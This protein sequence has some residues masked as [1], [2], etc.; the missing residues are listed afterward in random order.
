MSP[1][2]K[3]ELVSRRMRH[4]LLAGLAALGFGLGM[5]QALAQDE[6]EAVAQGE[7][8]EETAAEEHA[9]VHYPLKKPEMM[10][11]SFAG[12]FGTYDRGQLQ[13]GFQVYREVCA[14]CHSLHYVAFRT[15][16]DHDGPG[17]TDAQVAALAAE[18]TIP[19]G[20]NADGEMFDR[21]GRPSDRFP[22]PFP[23]EQAA[24]V[25]NGGAAPPDLS[26]M[27][28]ARS[29]PRGPLNTVLDFFTQYQEAGPDY[30]HA[31][32]TGYDQEPPHGIVVPDGVYYNPYFLGGPALAMP[33]PLSDGVVTYADGS[34]ETIE[35]YSRD[36]SAFL[37]WA[38]EPHLV[39]RKRLG[40]EVMIFVL[41]FASLMYLTKRRV[42]AAVAH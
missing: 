19:D 31:L 20:P 24:A 7:A 3:D 41:V 27:A 36:V 29:A 23:N 4:T 28:K 2:R 39:A 38:A 40:F 8:V 34:P 10:D 37:M 14:S 32:L 26:L 33:P 11:W 5:A 21:P 42:W 12:V 18:Y 1:F 35:Q 6:V 22:P 17:F 25:A 13:R 9:T 16:A 15:L 30:I